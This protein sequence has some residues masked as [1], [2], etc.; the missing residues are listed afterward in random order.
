MS[1]DPDEIDRIRRGL[2]AHKMA[3]GESDRW[4]SVQI[5]ALD[6]QRVQVPRRTLSRVLHGDSDNHQA[7]SAGARFLEKL[8]QKPTEMQLLADSVRALYKITEPRIRP[9]A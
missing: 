7:I 2:L 3:Y 5:A 8:P 4:L 1:D 9:G 6:P